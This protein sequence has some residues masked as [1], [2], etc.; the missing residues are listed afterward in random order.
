MRRLADHPAVA[1]ELAAELA[2]GDISP[3]WARLVCEWTDG[4]PAASR[5]AAD[6]ILLPAQAGGE[7]WP[8][9]RVGEKQGAKDHRTVPQ[10]YHDALE[11]AWQCWLPSCIVLGPAGDP[12]SGG[13]GH[14]GARLGGGIWGHSHAVAASEAWSGSG[15]CRR[16]A[17]VGTP[18]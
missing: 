15:A 17:S 12:L 9:C 8:T 10:R 16:T 2:A 11:E 14:G 6:R 18:V 1:A 7:S 13:P 3:S 5:A 4:L